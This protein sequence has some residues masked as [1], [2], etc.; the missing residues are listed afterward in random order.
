MENSLYEE[1]RV[2]EQASFNFVLRVYG[3]YEGCPPGTEMVWQEG[4]VMEFMERGSIHT[5]LVNLPGPPPW[6][7][8]FRLAHQ[9]ALGMNFLHSKH[10]VHQDLKPSNVLLDDGFNAKLADFGL[11]RPTTSFKGWDEEKTELIGGTDKYMPPEA[12]NSLYYPVRS[13]DIYSYGILLWSIFSGKKPYP[14]AKDNTLLK[15]R[16]SRGDRPLVEE[17]EKKQVDGLKASVELMIKCW[18]GDSSKRP[19]SSEI[20]RHT[21]KVSLKYKERIPNAIREV[22]NKLDPQTS[23]QDSQPSG[24]S[25]FTSVTPGQS[26]SEFATETSVSVGP[27]VLTEKEK[28]G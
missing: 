12:F 4:I 17:L 20:I 2:M 21:E 9:V 11:S 26:M 6:P 24:A 25:S 15:F 8:A 23:S 5:L 19:L 10:L 13:F 27:K 3:I 22:L 16:V 28:E 14:E 18:D 1:A 7:L